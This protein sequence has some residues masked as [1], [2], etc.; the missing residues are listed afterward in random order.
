MCVCV[1]VKDIQNLLEGITH[2]EG[3]ILDKDL[4]GNCNNVQFQGVRMDSG[5][6]DHPSLYILGRLYTISKVFVVDRFPEEYFPVLQVQVIDRLHLDFFFFFF[7][8]MGFT[9]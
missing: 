4:R 7:L 9:M 8:K 5:Q 3:V 6:R 2:M 1:C